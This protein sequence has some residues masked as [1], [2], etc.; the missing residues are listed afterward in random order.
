ML[1]NLLLAMTN[2]FAGRSC[3]RCGDS[4]VPGDR[5]GLSEGV[6]SGCRA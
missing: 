1:H 3:R 5:F 4:I 2:R 6:C